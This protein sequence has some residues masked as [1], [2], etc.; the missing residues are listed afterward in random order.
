MNKILVTGVTGQLGKAVIDLLI[1]KVSVSDIAVLVRDASK[2]ENLKAQGV[3]IRVG[4]F[5]DETSLVSGFKGI[6]KLY[7]VSSNDISNRLQQHQNVVNAAKTAGVKHVIYTSFQR[8]N[9]SADSPIAAIAESHLKTE[10]WLK[11]SGI[12]Y[13]F[14]QNSIYTDIVP[15]FL[16]EQ[17]LENGTI[18]FPAG[19]GKVSFALRQDMAEASV[20]ILTTEGHENKIYDFNSDQIITFQEIADILGEIAGKT[21]AYV[22]PTQEIYI[23]TL[24]SA[25]VPMEYVGMFAGFAEAFK[26]NEFDKTSNTLETLTGKKPVAVADFLKQVYA[27][28]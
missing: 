24:S 3:E 17:V 19:D 2:V 15:M 23:E 28:K 21:I 20:A 22:S 18:F 16:G 5:N 14:L 13:T 26:Q 27:A 10:Q 12:A 11:E 8:K 1:N 6:D 9:E 7:F 4:D 25:G